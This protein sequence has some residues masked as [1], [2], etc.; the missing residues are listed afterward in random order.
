M[1]VSKWSLDYEEETMVELQEMRTRH[2][3]STDFLGAREKRRFAYQIKY[4]NF[5]QC[6]MWCL[7]ASVVVLANETPNI[8]STFVYNQDWPNWFKNLYKCGAYVFTSFS[9]YIGNGHECYFAYNISHMYLQMNLLRAHVRQEMGRYRK[10]KLK[11]KIWSSVYQSRVREIF[12]RSVN[13]YN[14]LRLLVGHK[15]RGLFII[16]VRFSYGNKTALMYSTI[17]R[18]HFLNGAVVMSV[19]LN[20]VLHVSKT[21][22]TIVFTS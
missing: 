6:L 12:K 9:Y 19:A 18:W 2:F 15:L 4:F 8:Y 3:W 20:S 22:L 11:D 10:K 14:M 7:A 5:L 21:T 16:F 1:L 13:Q 17:C